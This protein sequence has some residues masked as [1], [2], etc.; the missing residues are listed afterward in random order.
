MA[1]SEGKKD[2]KRLSTGATLEL[3]PVLSGCRPDRNCHT[4][5]SKNE[6]LC[7][8]YGD[9]AI[10]CQT[11]ALNI[12]CKKYGHCSDVNSISCNACSYGTSEADCT[13]PFTPSEP[14]SEICDTLNQDLCS[15]YGDYAI[16]CQNG[17]I[18]TSCTKRGE[19]SNVKSSCT[20]CKYGTSEADCTDPFTPSG[21]ESEVCSTLN[22]DLCSKYSDYAIYCRTGGFQNSCNR[23]GHNHVPGK[24]SCTA[25]KYGTAKADCTD[26]FT[27][28]GP[29]SGFCDKINEDL[30][31]KYGDYAIYCQT[32]GI[33]ASCEKS[34]QCPNDARSLTP[35]LVLISVILTLGIK[36]AY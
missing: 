13:D 35:S 22:E 28:S 18:Q 16:Y 17:G 3:I 5:C 8:K 26:P 30:C 14:E 36:M 9:Y 2:T 31:T 7:S 21:P 20:A 10:Y 33:S 1:I 29:V 11:G 15:K 12:S 34:G 19:C 27:P 32:G 23:S 24:S 25:C 6:E 4:V